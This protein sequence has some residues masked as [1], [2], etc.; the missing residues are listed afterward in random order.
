MT[1][2]FLVTAGQTNWDTE[3]RIQGN[4]NVPLNA[5]GVVQI[6]RL[7]AERGDQRFDVIYTGES[8]D[9]VQTA[10]ILAKAWRVKVRKTGRLN[11]VDMG[12]WQG[13]LQSEA[14]RR[15]TH[16]YHRWQRD[17]LSVEPPDGE[18]IE[19]AYARIAGEVREI[20][21]RRRSQTVCLVCG[22]LAGTLAKCYLKDFDIR[23]VLE[24]CFEPGNCEMIEYR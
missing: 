4:L 22:P 21:K 3:E 24:L 2:V 17:P 8:Q 10:N 11:E 9:A 19:A 23:R 6:A 16:A 7:A 5:H 18:T 14:A 15:F 20:L 13:L 12:L 1:K